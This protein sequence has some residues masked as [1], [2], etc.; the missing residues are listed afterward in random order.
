MLE[1]SMPVEIWY[2]PEFKRDYKKLTPELQVLVKNRGR[3]FQKNPFHQLLKTHKLGGFVKECWAFSVK[4]GF[5]VIFEF[6]GDGKVNL[7]RVGDHSVY[8]KKK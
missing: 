1:S 6:R 2:G 8:R 3:L 7:L 4:Y 5:R